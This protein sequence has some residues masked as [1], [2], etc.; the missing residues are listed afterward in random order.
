MCGKWTAP[1]RN[2]SSSILDLIL[3]NSKSNHFGAQGTFKIKSSLCCRCVCGKWTAPFRNWSGL[4][5]H[6]KRKLST[7]HSF[8]FHRN[9]SLGA[10]SICEII[11]KISFLLQVRVWEMDGAVSQLVEF[12]V[13]AGCARCVAYHPT[14]YALAVGF[15]GESCCY[16]FYRPV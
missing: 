6:P 12:E 14:E 15:D 2:W 7:R 9:V 1:F 3:D 10:Y 8:L 11:V 4:K 16:S 5:E 13:A